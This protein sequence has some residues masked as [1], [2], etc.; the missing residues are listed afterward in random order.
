MNVFRDPEWLQEFQFQYQG[1]EEIPASVFDTINSNLD[2]IQSDDPL[3]SVVIAAWNEEINVLRCIASLSRTTTTLPIE[4]IVVDNNSTDKTAQTLDQLH[5]KKG[6]QPIQGWG[7]ARQ[8][9][10]EMA[11]GKYILLADADGY[12]PSD[13][14]SEMVGALQM[15][16]VACVYGRYAFRTAPGYPRWKLFLLEQMKNLISEVRH[17]KR[18]YLNACGMNMGFY[19]EQGLKIGFVMR[20][21]RGE[22]GRMCFDLMQYGRVKQVKSKRAVVWTNPRSLQRDGSFSQALGQRIIKEMRR[23]SSLFVPL[24]PHDTKT[25][26]N[27]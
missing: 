9:G 13:W 27:D 22:D 19:R 17:F 11:K 14:I 25:S 18:P 16:G 4:I 26:T 15:E 3:V 5:I 24:A 23:F 1:F 21:I 12:Y 2:R 7:P 6:F 8:L 10:M 20:H